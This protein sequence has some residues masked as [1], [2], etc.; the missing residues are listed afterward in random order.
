MRSRGNDGS[1][2]TYAAPRLSTAN[3]EAIILTPW[4]ITMPTRSPGRIIGAFDRMV[5]ESRSNRA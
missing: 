2:G 1:A 3:I 4:F 5:S